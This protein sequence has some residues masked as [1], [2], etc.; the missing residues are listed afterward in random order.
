MKANRKSHTSLQR[1][2]SV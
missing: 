2:R 1:D